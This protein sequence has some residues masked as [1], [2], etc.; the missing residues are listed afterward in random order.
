MG[1]CSRVPVCTPSY[2]G[3][4]SYVGYRHVPGSRTTVCRTGFF[5]DTVCA[6]RRSYYSPCDVYYRPRYYSSDCYHSGTDRAAAS[7]FLGC[8]GMGLL[9]A[10]LAV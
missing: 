1:Y 7:V 10:A 2:V 4:S 5:G 9:A 8:L 3:S 6:T